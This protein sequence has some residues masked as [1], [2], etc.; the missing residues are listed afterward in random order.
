[1]SSEIRFPTLLGLGVLVVGL[2]LGIFLV[3]KEQI[4]TTKATP[5]ELP[6]KIT[7]ANVSATSVSIYWQ[8]EIAISAFIQAGKTSTLGTTYRDDR[9]S[10]PQPHQLHFV[11]LSSL[12]PNT[13][14]YY[15][16]NNGSAIYPEGEP[17]TF[18]TITA[19]SPQTHQPLIG[20]ILSSVSQPIEEAFVTLEIP[21]AQSLAT[22]TKTFGN[23]VLPLSEIRSANLSDNFDLT[24]G[25][26][27][28]SLTIFNLEKSSKVNFEVPLK[29]SLPS[30]VLGQDLDLMPKIASPASSPKYDLNGDGVVNSLDLATLYKNFGKNS[31]NKASD[32]N[33]DG[34]VDQKDANILY[35]LIP[36]TAPDQ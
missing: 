8:T 34:V 14:Y 1:M 4:F 24:L 27:N 31:I 26:K 20:T 35:P 6:K 12:T 5:T 7:L 23:F 10:S 30:I 16:I 28:A 18:K 13:T 17:L 32:L 15:K 36:H 9:D 21:G 25:N 3:T 29:E 33:S 11:T 22:I 19:S 2:S